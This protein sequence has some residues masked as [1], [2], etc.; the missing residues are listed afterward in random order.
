MNRLFSHTTF[1]TYKVFNSKGHLF[2]MVPT[3]TEREVNNTEIKQKCSPVSRL[4]FRTILSE[5]KYSDW[6]LSKSIKC[7]IESLIAKNQIR[8]ATFHQDQQ[9]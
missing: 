9:L 8:R 5:T 7:T 4:L 6:Q 2:G 3:I 1:G